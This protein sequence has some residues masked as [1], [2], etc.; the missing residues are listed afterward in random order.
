MA[1]S[2]ACVYVHTV[3]STK[4]RQPAIHDEWRVDLFNVVGAGMKTLKCNSIIVG[5]VA[6]HLHILFELGRTIALSEA[7]GKIKSGSSNWINE[8]HSRAVPFQWQGGYA[9]FSVSLSAV[10][11]TREYIRTQESHHKIRTFQDELRE[12]FRKAGI[13][14]DERYVWD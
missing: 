14:W 3:F 4:N 1:Q 11:P 12:C 9:A 8:N 13:E 7:V 6:D 2:L 5:G 10:E